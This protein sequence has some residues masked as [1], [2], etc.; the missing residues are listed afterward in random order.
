M[1]AALVWSFL[2]AYAPL[3]GAQDRERIEVELGYAG[4]SRI[5][6][7][8]TLGEAS[9]QRLVE[10][11][12]DD[13]ARRA[14]VELW[15][16]QQLAAWIGPVAWEPVEL[17]VGGE[18]R[19]TAAGWLPPHEA[20][21]EVRGGAVHTTVHG[22]PELARFRYE[23]VQR[24]GGSLPVP[25]VY[26][27]LR[28]GAAGLEEVRRLARSVGEPGGSRELVL[29]LPGPVESCER[30]QGV[31]ELDPLSFH[32]ER[33]VPLW[34][35]TW[36][37]SDATATAPSSDGNRVTV[38]QTAADRTGALDRRLAGLVAT[39]REVETGG[40]TLDDAVAAVESRVEVVRVEGWSLAGRTSPAAVDSFSR[41]FE[42]A[43]AAWAASPWRERVEQAR[44]P[45]PVPGIE[46]LAPLAPASTPPPA[47]P[48]QGASP[49]HAWPVRTGEQHGLWCDL[50]A[51]FRIDLKAGQT[52]HVEVRPPGDGDLDLEL[53]ADGKTRRELVASSAAGTPVEAA[54]W[55]A[56]K[57]GPVWARVWKGTARFTLVVRVE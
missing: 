29:V 41:G 50:E 33:W 54:T 13:V 37:P 20:L 25:S 43:Q 36:T 53:W 15:A 27:S 2:I 40:G 3:A 51:W 24:S 4:P 42:A 52:V 47:A 38:V 34:R 45:V 19:L 5:R 31:A 39:A 12:L 35:G 32:G 23:V 26:E 48:A 28:L 9:T 56:A 55:K 57:D 8:V 44:T 1:R 18:V 30:D 17:L 7:D 14:A 6:L 10:G 21:A 11:Q 22:H 49:D 46:P 16:A